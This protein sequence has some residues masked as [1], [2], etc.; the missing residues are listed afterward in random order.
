M[1]IVTG[2]AG[3][4]GSNLVNALIEKSYDVFLCDYPNMLKSDYFKEF[5]KIKDYYQIIYSSILVII[6]LISYIPR[7]N[8]RNYS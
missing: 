5:Q 1:I 6:M 3:F 2:G 4:I 7:S 8:F